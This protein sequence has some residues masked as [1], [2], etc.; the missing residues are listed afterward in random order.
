MGDLEVAPP[1]SA[2]LSFLNSVWEPGERRIQNRLRLIDPAFAFRIKRVVNNKLA[3][4]NLVVRQSECPKAARDPTQTFTSRVRIGWMRISRA[5]NF[6]KKQE[7]RLSQI[8]FLQ[9]GIEGDILAVMSELAVRNIEYGSVVDFPPLG[10]MRKEYKLRFGIDKI[11][12][13]PR[14]GHAI[15][16]NFFTRDPFHAGTLTGLAEHPN[17]LFP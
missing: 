5:D 7:R 4:K 12:D 17:R 3:L 13:Q 15:D 8:V 10:L 11:P 9:D 16:F 14:T 1:V 6:R 2:N